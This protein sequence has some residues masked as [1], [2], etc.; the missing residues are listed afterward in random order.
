MEGKGMQ[1]TWEMAVCP[2][3]G[4]AV[5]TMRSTTGRARAAGTG[6]LA[7]HYTHVDGVAMECVGSVL[8]SSGRNA[9]GIPLYVRAAA[10]TEAGQRP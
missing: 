4:A 5:G 2:Y 10:R 1:M 3:C 6:F 9:A 8:P 7:T